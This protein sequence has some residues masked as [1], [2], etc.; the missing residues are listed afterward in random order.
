MKI[1]LYLVMSFFCFCSHAVL[2][3]KPST[4][5]SSK[6]APPQKQIS[7]GGS[8][9]ISS[10]PAA[11]EAAPGNGFLQHLIEK[12]LGIKNNHGFNYGGVWLGDADEALATGVPN[13]KRLTG[14]S[15][16][17]LN[18]TWDPSATTHWKGGLFD[19]EYLQL[20][21]Q[22]TNRQVGSV[23]GYNSIP[24][25]PPL[26][27]SELYQLWYRQLLFHDKLMIRVGKLVPT[28][29]FNNVIKPVPVK[30]QSLAIPVVTSLIYTPIFINPTL[31]GVLP[32]YYNSAYGAVASVMPTKNTYVS[33]GIYDGSLAQGIQTGLEGPHFNGTNVQIGETGMSW[34]IKGLPGTV[35]VGAW[36]QTGLVQNPPPL[37]L[38]ENG[39]SGIYSF[40]AQRVWF[41]DPSV[42]NSGVSLFYQYGIND[43]DVM[44]MNQFVGFGITGYGLLFH[45]PDDS[46]GFGLA[47][48]WLNQRIFSRT[49][50]AML[51]LYYQAK[52][53]NEV[54]LEPVMSFIP[55]PGAN[56]ELSSS[57]A[58]TLRAVV[59]F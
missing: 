2:S 12:N 3:A 43:S 4:H 19:A 38:E 42:N 13:P 31:I 8:E 52:V 39:A 26:E 11:V 46:I 10:N 40:G 54:Y 25:P 7:E 44:P 6:Q 35:S 24:G 16:L 56:P 53:T 27:R 28:I 50:E 34:I 48:S 18:L 59:L 5:N 55:N 17:L 1:Y 15:L 33:Y 47:N 23:Q 37:I 57:W 58:G 21:A 14:N 41:K 20:N 22:E 29:D 49:Q 9:N 32:G 30:Q 51:Q 36:H 45:R